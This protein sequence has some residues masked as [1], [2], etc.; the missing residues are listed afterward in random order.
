MSFLMG[1][2]TYP[3]QDTAQEISKILVEERIVA[4]ANIFQINSNYWWENMIRSEDEW[5][6]LVK[7][8][9]ENRLALVI[10]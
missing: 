2:I 8:T 6:S 4:C 1:Y 3:D 9:K 7:T 5:V 10:T